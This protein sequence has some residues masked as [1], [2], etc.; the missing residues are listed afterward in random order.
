MKESDNFNCRR[1]G[2]TS[3]LHSQ[4]YSGHDDER[5][6]DQSAGESRR[7]LRHSES[8]ERRRPPDVFDLVHS[9]FQLHAVLRGGYRRKRHG[10]VQ[11]SAGLVGGMRRYYLLRLCLPISSPVRA[12]GTSRGVKKSRTHSQPADECIDDRFNSRGRRPLA[13]G[14]KKEKKKIFTYEPLGEVY[15]GGMRLP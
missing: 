15:D 10:P 11:S 8:T 3:T 7:G 12:T 9:Q 14:K 2:L 13:A 1:K 4:K 5:L 6:E